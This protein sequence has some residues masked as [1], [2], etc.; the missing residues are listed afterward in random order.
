MSKETKET[1]LSICL[2]MK[3]KGFHS[4]IP[5]GF[6]VKEDDPLQAR[7]DFLETVE[8]MYDCGHINLHSLAALTLI[9]NYEFHLAMT[10]SEE[11]TLLSIARLT[12]NEP[13]I[14]LYFPLIRAAVI[15]WMIDIEEEQQRKKKPKILSLMSKLKII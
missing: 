9:K 3:E 1:V 13:D 6:F 8:V 15:T 14:P 5:D 10:E 11:D 2:D 4:H 7:I 12:K